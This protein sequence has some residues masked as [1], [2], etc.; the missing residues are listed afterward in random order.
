MRFRGGADPSEIDIRPVTEP[1]DLGFFPKPPDVEG[2][3]FMIMH[4]ADRT[5]EAGGTPERFAEF[6][7]VRGELQGTGVLLTAEALTPT[8]DAVRLKFRD[9]RRT[10]IDGPTPSRR[11]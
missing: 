4:K 2:T 8:T 7:R 1:W 11:S 3:R 9:G 5:S 10:V 6:A